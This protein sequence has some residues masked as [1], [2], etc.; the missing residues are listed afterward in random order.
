MKLL[1]MLLA[2]LA[3]GV[4][5][6]AELADWKLA[7]P[8]PD[9]TET[10][11]T[12][13]NL[14]AEKFIA[15]DLGETQDY[16]TPEFPG[17]IFFHELW[18]GQ[19]LNN[20]MAL[21]ATV[22]KIEKP[23]YYRMAV[24]HDCS[25]DIF[26]NGKKIYSKDGWQE[27][28]PF[29]AEL[30]SGD[31]LLVL[32]NMHHES[33]WG[34]R[35]YLEAG[36][37]TQDEVDSQLA[38]LEFAK[39]YAEFSNLRP[40]IDS[41]SI[42]QTGDFGKFEWNGTTALKLELTPIWL[43]ADF[44]PVKKAEQPGL[45]YL[46]LEGTVNGKVHYRRYFP[47]YAVPE[48]WLESPE[49]KDRLAD[50]VQDPWAPWK[51]YDYPGILDNLYAKRTPE[52]FDVSKKLLAQRAGHMI[53]KPA[54]PQKLA[55]PATTLRFGTEAEAGVP[56]GTADK[57][58][59]IMSEW[60]KETGEPF[61]TIFAKNGVIFYS[62]SYGKADAS[63]VCRLAS[64]SKFM[65]AV[66]YARFVDQGILDIDQPM[67]NVL[68]SLTMLTPRS[69]F[70]H[71]CGMEGHYGFG[72]LGNVWLDEAIAPTL[73]PE[74]IGVTHSYNGNGYNL[75]GLQMMVAAGTPIDELYRENYYTPLGITDMTGCDQGGGYRAS[76]DDLAIFAQLMLNKGSYGDWK[77]FSEDTY[78]KMLPVE[79]KDYF[80]KTKEKRQWGMGLTYYGPKVDGMERVL[81]HGSATGCL[82]L[83]NPD[84]QAFIVQARAKRGDKYQ[85]YSDKVVKLLAELK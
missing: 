83:F 57:L 68:P 58:D 50:F 65:T 9:A 61:H 56:A 85:E 82:F 59:A 7:G 11:Q 77:F 53:R 64:I 47:F 22:I 78:R 73:N 6:A 23:G 60:Y 30:K 29:F 69:C 79:L 36:P 52:Y 10:E 44:N 45:Y 80:P 67:S 31:N 16:S 15:G 62:K 49:M 38:A 74:N 76:T 20:T 42:I 39:D 46:K 13:A 34:V 17:K 28:T 5:N 35:I 48:N 72:G 1:S 24:A 2:A 37:F 81:G 18:S 14:R 66:L 54:P 25:M 32:K 41:N 4:L 55:V 26:V 84:A 75:L 27:A 63:R 8:L 19:D 71:M 43:D 51:V 33:W 3:A 70:T 21:A 12:A 40:L